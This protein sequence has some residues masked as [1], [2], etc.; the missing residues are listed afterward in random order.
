[1]VA[2]SPVRRPAAPRTSEPV[3]TEVVN[4]VVRWASR[5][6]ATTR[7]SVSS[8][9]V[10]TPPGNTTT[11]GAGTS[12]NVASTVSPSMP[13]SLRTSPRSWPTKVMSNLGMRW[14]TS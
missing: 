2:L 4:R 8:G 10:P 9:R 3:Q 14:R 1:M 12:S 7:R 5:T 6:Q 13:F 11:S